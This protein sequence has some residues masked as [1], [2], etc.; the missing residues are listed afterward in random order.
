MDAQ[1]DEK[2][3]GLNRIWMILG[4]GDGLSHSK[5]QIIPAS[6]SGLDEIRHLIGYGCFLLMN[7][8]WMILGLYGIC[9]SRQ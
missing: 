1:M 9:P 3:E 6:E 4:Q 7:R 8:V 5:V 2:R